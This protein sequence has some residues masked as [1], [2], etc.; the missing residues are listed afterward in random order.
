[1]RV[2]DLTQPLGPDTVMWP[3]CAS[4]VFDI[5]ETHG[6]HG[7]FSRAVSLSE[8][9]GTHVD[10]PAHFAADAPTIDQIPAEHLVCPLAVVDVRDQAA[11]NA[12]YCLPV[13]DLERD[14]AANGPIEPGS[15]VVIHTGWGRRGADPAAYLGIGDDGVLHFPGIGR[16]SAEWLI[17]RRQIRGIGID[18]AGVDRG[19]DTAFEVHAEVTLPQGVW[20]VEGL[21]NLDA[22]PARGA[23]LFVGA[24]PF[25]GGSGAPARVIAVVPDPAPGAFMPLQRM[26]RIT[27]FVP[28][29]HVDSLLEGVLR[30]APL[31][32][33]PYDRCAWWSAAGVEQFRPLPG[34]T[35]TVGTPGQV[36]RVPAIRLEFAIPR[37][38]A[39]LEQVLTRGVIACH[40]WQEPAIFVDD[41]LATASHLRSS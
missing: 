36:E 35:P 3:G 34:S 5:T 14:E 41:S 37:D 8:H 21:V 32:Y 23:T 17:R 40:P 28:P 10:A 26:Y 18:T 30:E 22:V 33:G 2:I 7:T 9:S 27:T 6:E 20:Q 31:T 11:E 16:R 15:A 19:A 24:I 13:A 12:D 1:V 4:P 38:P 39:L 29:G 25:R